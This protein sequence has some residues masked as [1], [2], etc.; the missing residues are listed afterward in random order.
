MSLQHIVDHIYGRN[1][2]I[3]RQDRPNMFIKELDIYVNYLQD[4]YD[5]FQKH[6]RVKQQKQLL[7][8]SKNLNEGISYY[9]SL[10]GTVKGYFEKQSK[11]VLSQLESYTIKVNNLQK[12]IEAYTE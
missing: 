12:N 11:T 2:M 10:F 9:K 4:R 8:F 6:A 1:Q 7:N 3:T 5:D